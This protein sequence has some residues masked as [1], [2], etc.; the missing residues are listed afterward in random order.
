MGFFLHK[1]KEK[2]KNV[3]QKRFRYKGPIPRS[4][5]TAILMLADGCE[6]SLR[7]LGLKATESEAKLTIKRIIETGSIITVAA[8]NIEPAAPTPDLIIIPK[9]GIESIGTNS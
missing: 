1:A 9:V 5:E 7:A 3:S 6:A 8:R 4:R 2:D